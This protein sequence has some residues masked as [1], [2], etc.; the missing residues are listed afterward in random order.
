MWQVLN[1]KNNLSYENLLG[2]VRAFWP[3]VWHLLTADDCLRL[4]PT[5]DGIGV[6]LVGFVCVALCV[7]VL[8]IT[9]FHYGR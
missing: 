6:E 2:N 7:V 9:L 5:H 8:M 4:L 3:N 1:R